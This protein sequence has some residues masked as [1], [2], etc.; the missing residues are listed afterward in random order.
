MKK[1][2]LPLAQ[3]PAIRN[4]R[5]EIPKAALARWEP[6][7]R[8][9]ADEDEA[10]ISVLDP[11]GADFFGDGVTARRI[12]AAL[13]NIGERDV[14]VNINSPGG[15]YHEGLAIYNLFRQHPGKITMRVLGEAASAAS[16]IAM[17]GDRIEIGRAAFFMIHN[18]W[19]MAAG[20][21]N[22]MR[23]VADMLEPF[24]RA[25]ADVYAARSG[26]DADEIATMM[27]RETWIA[28]AEAVEDGFADDFLAADKI[29]SSAKSQRTEQWARLMIVA[30]AVAQG[31]HWSD[32]AALIEGMVAG[33]RF[34]RN[35]IDAIL[36]NDGKSRRERRALMNE[37]GMPCAAEDGVQH[38]A[39]EAGLRDILQRY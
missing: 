20:D 34:A 7:I 8:A 28:G 31:R 25:A 22:F 12:N 4:G 26:V 30:T 18:V 2:S 10:T 39:V 6:G 3:V 19:V 33:S 16:V 14:I 23:E 17:A 13:R 1:L 32:A 27:D 36:A 9:A 35:E 21:R 24:D 38:A 5:W 11:I 37:A 29:D 15:D